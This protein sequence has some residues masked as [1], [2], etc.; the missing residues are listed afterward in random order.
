[1][2]K[3]FYFKDKKY[4][5]GCCFRETIIKINSICIVINLFKDLEWKLYLYKND[6]YVSEHTISEEFANKLIN[7]AAEYQQYL[8]E[9]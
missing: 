7:E 1:M 2:I 3:T 6:K 8:Y 9:S 4:T 5:L